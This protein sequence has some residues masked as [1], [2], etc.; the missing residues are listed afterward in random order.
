[1][2]KS[3]ITWGG[4]TSLYSTDGLPT[5]LRITSPPP[6]MVY[7][8][9]LAHLQHHTL[10]VGVL[11]SKKSSEIKKGG[12]AAEH[13]HIQQGCRKWCWLMPQTSCLTFVPP[14]GKFQLPRWGPHCNLNLVAGQ[15]R[16]SSYSKASVP[17]QA[18]LR[19]VFLSQPTVNPCFGSLHNF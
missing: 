11:E 13:T 12:A 14:A 3:M 15:N 6:I 10:T 19:R 5:S 4:T 18:Y 7:P 17:H 1:M 8:V 16:L 2:H 9:F